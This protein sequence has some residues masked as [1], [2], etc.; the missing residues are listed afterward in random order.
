MNVWS[1][2]LSV[3]LAGGAEFSLSD[4]STNS[5]CVERQQQI[6]ALPLPYRLRSGRAADFSRA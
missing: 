4:R 2:A 1:S 6:N 5:F 3:R